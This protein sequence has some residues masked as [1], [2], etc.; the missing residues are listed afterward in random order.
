M[1]IHMNVDPKLWQQY[2]ETWVFVMFSRCVCQG[3]ITGV[4]VIAGFCLLP[5]GYVITDCIVAI[6]WF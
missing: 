2:A 1:F 3:N 4:Q 6:V 5:L